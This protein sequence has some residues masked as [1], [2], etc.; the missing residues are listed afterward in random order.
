M[1]KYNKNP[2]RK[3]KKTFNLLLQIIKKFHNPKLIVLKIGGYYEF[4][5]TTKE[6][7][8]LL[9][10]KKNKNAKEVFTLDVRDSK[11]LKEYLTASFSDSKIKSG[12]NL[13][14]VSVQQIIDCIRESN[15]D[16]FSI[17]KNGKQIGKVSLALNGK[18]L[19]ELTKSDIEI[20]LQE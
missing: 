20:I 9:H 6:I 7:T 16:C 2:Y 17:K 11:K 8:Y 10:K 12:G 15:F 19:D 4:H 1:S 13:Y 5:S 18:I 14:S 3:Q